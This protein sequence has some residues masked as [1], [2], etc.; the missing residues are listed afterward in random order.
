MAATAVHRNSSSLI[1]REVLLH[2]NNMQA[3]SKI[4]A[5]FGK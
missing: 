3:L 2:P 5:I 4:T 1:I